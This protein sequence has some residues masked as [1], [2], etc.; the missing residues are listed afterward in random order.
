VTEASQG[1]CESDFR[2]VPVREIPHL[3]PIGHRDAGNVTLSGPGRPFSGRDRGAGNALR[4]FTLLWHGQSTQRVRD[5]WTTREKARRSRHLRD[6]VGLPSRI[7]ATPVT[8]PRET[9]HTFRTPAPLATATACP[10]R[11][12]RGASLAVPGDSLRGPIPSPARSSWNQPSRRGRGSASAVLYGAVGSIKNSRRG[13]SAIEEA[14]ET[15]QAGVPLGA[16]GGEPGRGVGERAGVE[17]EE[18]LAAAAA[19]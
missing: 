16:D 3:G 8:L 1:R 9:L 13:G 17:L 11:G 10:G 18:G 4:G 14:L 5:C 15:G 12:E 19:L 2:D 7:R 6:G